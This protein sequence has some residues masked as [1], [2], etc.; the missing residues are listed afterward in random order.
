[1]TNYMKEF[2]KYLLIYFPLGVLFVATSV[3]VASLV[4]E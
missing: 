3:L 1:M 2:L 4:P